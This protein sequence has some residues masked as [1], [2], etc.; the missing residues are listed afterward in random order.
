MGEL[1]DP[2]V[3]GFPLRG[4][5]W[6]AVTT[7]AARIPSHGVDLLGQRYA[8]DFVRVDDRPG[9]PVHPA[10]RLRTAT[11]GCRADECYAWDEPVHAPF[12]A[13]VVA[14]SDGMAER[15]WIHPVREFARMTW[16]GLTFRPSRIPA[17]LGN[18]VLLRAGDVHAGFAHLRPGSVAVRAG[19]TVRAGEV[20]GAVGHTGN[21]TSP[22]LHFQLMDRAD[23]MRAR[24]IACAFAAYDVRGDDGS[25]RRV[26]R[27]IPAPHERLRSAETA[28]AS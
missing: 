27:G 6:V 3:V 22:H 19:E 17:I 20:I 4:E 18:H 15:R 24:G 21:S 26:E 16:N 12:D 5:G 10:S 8:Y 13:V 2:V 11:I 23:L 7:P 14:A 28:A 1:D 9:V 25:W